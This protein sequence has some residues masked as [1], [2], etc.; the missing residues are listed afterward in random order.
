MTYTFE[1][2]SDH[3]GGQKYRHSIVN[4]WEGQT[5]LSTESTIFRDEDD[6]D[7]ETRRFSSSTVLQHG[8]G[9]MLI[10]AAGDDAKFSSGF[11]NV[12]QEEMKD[13]DPEIYQPRHGSCFLRCLSCWTGNITLSRRSYVLLAVIIIVLVIMITIGCAIGVSSKTSNMEIPAPSPIRTLTR[14]PTS[15]PHKHTVQQTFAHELVSSLLIHYD[16]LDVHDFRDTQSPQHLAVIYLVGSTLSKHQ[17]N[18][19]HFNKD[20]KTIQALRNL[21]ELYSL[22]VLYYSTRGHQWS[23]ADRWLNRSLEN[24]CTWHGI[25][26]NTNQSTTITTS[27]R[28]STV[29]HVIL[30]NNNLNGTLPMELQYLDSLVALDL[31]QNSLRGSLP[32]ILPPF[33]TTASFANNNLSQH[34]PD[35]WQQ[36][37]HLEVLNLQEN[38]LRGT[39]PLLTSL[40][41]LRGQH[42][43]FTGT[44]PS[45]PNLEELIPDDNQ[46]TGS[47]P[48]NL[49]RNLKILSVR[50][51]LLNGSFPNNLGEQLSLLEILNVGENVMVGSLQGCAGLERLEQLYVDQNLFRGRLPSFT[52]PFL[53]T[54]VASNN[55]LTGSLPDT[56]TVGAV[57]TQ[58]TASVVASSSSNLQVL[59]LNDNDFSGSIPETMLADLSHLK[60]LDLSANNDLVGTIP[61]YLVTQL[62]ELYLPPNVGI[63]N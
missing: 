35:T 29:T 45:T 26:C 21:V 40:R 55:Q 59:E 2:S 1:S 44:V 5:S 38:E 17:L 9:D 6:V 3:S 4:V 60:V 14:R 31:S 51:N 13:T 33:L 47:I 12:T 8:D 16:I 7:D 61:S 20:W 53:V 57:V 43:F 36:L 32:E 42:N 18:R 30:N 63:G 24:P 52:S 37:S 25:A 22:A 41:V 27:M 50:K 54:L 19:A 48:G 56:L 15:P 62:D 11:Q 23:S 10:H 34:V 49:S 58:D 39:L 46:L 28:L